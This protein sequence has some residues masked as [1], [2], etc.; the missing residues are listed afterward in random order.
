MRNIS[1]DHIGLSI[2]ENY[3]YAF[4]KFLHDNLDKDLYKN[5]Y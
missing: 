3:D 1:I 2:F 5:I 4:F